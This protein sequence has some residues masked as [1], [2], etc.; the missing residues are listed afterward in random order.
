MATS[1]IYRLFLYK[2]ASS[3]LRTGIR[4]ILLNSLSSSFPLEPKA[5]QLL[6]CEAYDKRICVRK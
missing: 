1:F 5:E 6:K 4:R 2:T 3:S